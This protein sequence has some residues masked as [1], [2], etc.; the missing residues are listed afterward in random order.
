MVQV[1]IFLKKIDMLTRV[2]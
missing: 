1:G 2:L